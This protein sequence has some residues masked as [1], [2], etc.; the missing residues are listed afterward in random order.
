[1]RT[2]SKW[3]DKGRTRGPEELA[4]VVAMTLWRLGINTLR[5]MRRADYDI[6]TGPPYFDF[7]REYLVFLANLADRYVF[8]HVEADE[9]RSFLTTLVVRLGE[10]LAENQAELVGTDYGQAKQAFVD[11]FN[12]RSADYAHFEFGDDGPEYGFARYCG[13]KLM[14]VL[15]EKDRVWVVEQ[16]VSIEA[17]EAV[18]TLKTAFSNLFATPASGQTPT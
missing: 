14:D 6:V 1:M 4:T 3:F 5:S 17:P 9:R 13:N 16:V 2:K 8:P 15:P 11:L 18:N 7:L 12:L 10:M